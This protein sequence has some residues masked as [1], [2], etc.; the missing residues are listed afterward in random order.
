MKEYYKKYKD[1]II[2]KQE[3]DKMHQRV[4]EKFNEFDKF[5]KVEEEILNVFETIKIQ[6][7]QY[8]NFD[9]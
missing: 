5:K 6:Q 8:E 4:R 7:E 9:L 1:N 3:K 2:T